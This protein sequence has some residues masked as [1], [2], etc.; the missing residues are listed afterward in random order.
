MHSSHFIFQRMHIQVYTNAPN[1]RFLT[2][3]FE[4][5]H[6]PGSKLSGFDNHY[7]IKLRATGYRL[8][9]E[10]VDKG[11]YILV[12]VVGKRDKNMVYKKIAK[13]K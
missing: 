5:P 6:V 1:A 12:I 9:Y 2:T 7:K 8:V 3:V 4:S 13:T 11:I 10:V